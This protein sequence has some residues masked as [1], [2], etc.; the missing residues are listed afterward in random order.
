[1]RHAAATSRRFLIPATGALAVSVAMT[2]PL[3]AGL[4]RLGRTTADGLY[5]I[6]N[7]A[8][9]AHAI[10]SAPRRLFDANIFHPTLYEIVSFP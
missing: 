4:T 6:W 9:V 7:V 2:W 5:S 10:S 3:A 1:M 8:W